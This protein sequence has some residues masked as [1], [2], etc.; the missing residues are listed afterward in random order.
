MFMICVH[1]RL[2]A[3][4]A[5]INA[6]AW[7]I[8]SPRACTIPPSAQGRTPLD[9]LSAELAGFLRPSPT[10]G[11]TSTDVFAWGNGANY[12]LVRANAHFPRGVL[13]QPRLLGAEHTRSFATLHSPCR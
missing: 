12:G 8:H 6:P 3:V 7:L 2:A 13:S 9:L 11:G 1:A 5:R 10:G 4:H